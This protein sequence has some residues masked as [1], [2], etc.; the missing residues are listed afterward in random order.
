MSAAAWTLEDLQ[1]PGPYEAEDLALD[2]SFALRRL[3]DYAGYL[4]T[5]TDWNYAPWDPAYKLSLVVDNVFTRALT[6]RNATWRIKLE[7][8]RSDNIIGLIMTKPEKK[9]A[10]KVKLS[11][12]LL[13]MWTSEG[14]ELAPLPFDQGGP[15]I[16]DRIAAVCADFF[17]DADGNMPKDD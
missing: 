5:R 9:A 4:W 7:R 11:R 3:G 17:G 10:L 2:V 1:G 14:A 12:D 15:A 6:S 8:S 13:R 16:I